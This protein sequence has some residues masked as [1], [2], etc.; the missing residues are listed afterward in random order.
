M[1]TFQKISVAVLCVVL[2]ACGQTPQPNP[3][4]SVQAVNPITASSATTYECSHDSNASSLIVRINRTT[5]PTGRIYAVSVA[6][7]GS[8]ISVSEPQFVAAGA[9]ATFRLETRR[10]PPG[11]YELPITASSGRSTLE[12]AVQVR[13]IAAAEGVA[14][15][16]FTRLEGFTDAFSSVHAAPDGS[17]YAS[18]ATVPNNGLQ[19]G[20]IR[21]YAQGATV[22]SVL[23]STPAVVGGSSAIA[24]LAS[25]VAGAVYA[26]EI[27][28]TPDLSQ[29]S[30][31]AIAGRVLRQGASG[32]L[33]VPLPLQ[34][35]EAPFAFV[36]WNNTL[37][38]STVRFNPNGSRLIAVDSGL[39]LL[40]APA[41][42]TIAVLR[43]IGAG[44]FVAT[45]NPN[46]SV[47]KVY[48]WRAGVL[49]QRC[50]FVGGVSSLVSDAQGG[51]LIGTQSAVY[52]LSPTSN[53]CTPDTR[54]WAANRLL[55]DGSRGL[56]GA[57][58]PYSTG[59]LLQDQ[60]GAGIAVYAGQPLPGANQITETDGRL[61]IATASGL[62]R[63]TP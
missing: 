47:S 57:S 37:Y 7:P 58:A 61:W 8:G 36:T 4:A 15:D 32:W 42:E 6:S 25:D 2:A 22:S 46:T 16:C 12:G 10:T 27:S 53:T 29:P 45:I 41:G 28:Q 14:G 34:R 24:R 21:R 23:Y 56:Y 26:S 60:G 49:T 39:T 40:S 31:V 54:T 55:F 19:L 1:E 13:V 35:G 59:D 52:K 5:F 9:P 11:W 33:A 20:L 18:Y 30:S 63:L 3:S 38:V 44:L 62:Y 51:V 43:S 48:E 17:V 50:S